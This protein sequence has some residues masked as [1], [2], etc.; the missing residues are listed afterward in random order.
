MHD[1]WASRVWQREHNRTTYRTRVFYVLA[2]AVQ[3]YILIPIERI[4]FSFFC[5]FCY[6]CICILNNTPISSQLKWAYAMVPWHIYTIHKNIKSQQKRFIS[7]CC[8]ILSNGVWFYVCILRCMKWNAFWTIV[9]CCFDL[10]RSSMGVAS[11][12]EQMTSVASVDG[13]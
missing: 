11:T 10:L 5:F 8:F 12:V 9:S 2:Y 7:W 4:I 1:A 3:P 6:W 13:R